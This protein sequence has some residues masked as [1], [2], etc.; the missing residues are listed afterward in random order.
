MNWGGGMG[1]N[2]Q[3]MVAIE[4]VI[5]SVWNVKNQTCLRISPWKAEWRLDWRK[6]VQTDMERSQFERYL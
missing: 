5:S 3:S 2:I 1:I 4:R 6:A